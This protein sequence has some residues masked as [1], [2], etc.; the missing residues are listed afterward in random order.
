MKQNE[1]MNFNIGIKYIYF[2]TFTNIYSYNS[3]K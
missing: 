2:N 3:G 1:S